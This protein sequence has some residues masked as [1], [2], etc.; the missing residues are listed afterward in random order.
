M[1]LKSL[2]EILAHLEHSSIMKRPT[3]PENL[4]R[5]VSDAPVGRLNPQLREMYSFGCPHPTPAT[6]K[7]Q[8]SLLLPIL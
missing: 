2:G 8:G 1:T 5:I 6:P 4:V 7:R 3:I